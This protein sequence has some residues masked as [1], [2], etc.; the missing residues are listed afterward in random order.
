MAGSFINAETLKPEPRDMKVKKEERD[1]NNHLS[2]IKT[3]RPLLCIAEPV[4]EIIQI[5]IEDGAGYAED[6]LNATE[7]AAVTFTDGELDSTIKTET[8]FPEDET[9]VL[10]VKIEEDEASDCADGKSS[11]DERN[12]SLQTSQS[13]LQSPSVPD[14]SSSPHSMDTECGK[15]FSAK[16]KLDLHQVGH[17]AE[18]KYKCR[19][20]ANNFSQESHQ[21]EHTEEKSYTHSESASLTSC[22]YYQQ[23][24]R[25]KPYPCTECEKRFCKKKTLLTHLKNHTGEKPFTCSEC[26]KCFTEKIRLQEHQKVHTGER[27]FICTECG[28]GFSKKDRLQTHLIV[29]TRETPH[30]CK[31]CGKSFSLK[32]SLVRHQRVHTGEKPFTCTLCGKSFSTKCWLQSHQTVHTGEKPFACLSFRIFGPSDTQ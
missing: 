21:Q 25:P 6:D 16:R 14:S 11:N 20:G 23:N 27:P 4:P 12:G 32:N 17:I 2:Q 7:C 13:G 29:H 19:E 10:K 28:K 5:K 24:H 30:A 15:C 9:E 18:M 1:S 26:G 22:L 31:E 3:E 8:G